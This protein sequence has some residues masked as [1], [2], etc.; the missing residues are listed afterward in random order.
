MYGP[1]N[2]TNSNSNVKKMAT[3][4]REKDLNSSDNESPEES[5]T[6]MCVSFLFFFI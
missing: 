1:Y 6:G 3:L 2:N 5:D 4:L